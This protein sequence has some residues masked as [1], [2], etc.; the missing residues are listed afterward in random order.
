MAQQLNIKQRRSGGARIIAL[1][2]LSSMRQRKLAQ[3]RRSWLN[4]A[5]YQRAVAPTGGVPWFV[6]R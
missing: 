2:Q 4:I 3:R 1:A 5:A 6:L